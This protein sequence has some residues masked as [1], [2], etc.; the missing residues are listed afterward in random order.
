[1][2]YWHGI[3]DMERPYAARPAA[4]DVLS[5]D[6]IWTEQRAQSGRLPADWSDEESHRWMGG[7]LP[8]SIRPPPPFLTVYVYPGPSS[9]A[10][11]RQKFFSVKGREG[12]GES[13][14]DGESRAQPPPLHS[15]VPRPAGCTSTPQRA[16]L[17]AV[18][19]H[20]TKPNHIQL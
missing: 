7:V 18:P 19:W 10:A 16:R 11:A 17:I 4:R 1:M 12:E 8:L 20:N 5:N 9:P 6:S 15:C 13:N 14:D 2:A 3:A